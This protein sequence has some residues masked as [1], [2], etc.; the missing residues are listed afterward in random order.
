MIKLYTDPAC[1]AL[2]QAI[3]DCADEHYGPDPDH[4]NMYEYLEKTPRASLVAEIVQKLEANGFKIVE[5]K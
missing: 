5:A 4:Y 1:N 2:Y 3:M